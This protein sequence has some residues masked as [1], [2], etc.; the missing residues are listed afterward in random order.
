MVIQNSID[1]KGW[2]TAYKIYFECLD[3]N[4]IKWFQYRV[5]NS[6]LGTR[7]YLYRVKIGDSPLCGYCNNAE[8]TIIH[9]MCDCTEVKTLW[10]DLK[11]FVFRQIQVN[12]DTDHRLILL[13]YHKQ[14]PNHLVLNIIYLVTK[15][16]FLTAPEKKVNPS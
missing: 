8:E 11:Y 1:I 4:I 14:D 13:G 7:S 10:I 15:N 9:L 2:E 12:L 5:L 3:D 16:I 6:I